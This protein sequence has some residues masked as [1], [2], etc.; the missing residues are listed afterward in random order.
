[1]SRRI[2]DA[3]IDQLL[4]GRSHGPG[5]LREDGLIGKLSERLAEG[6]LAT[7][8][9]VYLAIGITCAGQKEVLGLWLEQTE[10]AKCWLRVMTD[11]KGRGVQELLIAVVDGLKGFLEAITAVF[12]QTIVQ[13][14]IVHLLRC[15]LDLASWKERRALAAALKPI[16]TA[17][18]AEAS[19]R[20]WRGRTRRR[21]LRFSSA[22]GFTSPPDHRSACTH[23]SEHAP[24]NSEHAPAKRLR[25][26][27]RATAIIWRLL[28]VAEKR[29]RK[30]S[31][32]AM[33]GRVPHR[34]L[35][36]RPR[37]AR[38]FNH[39]KGRRLTRMYTFLDETSRRPVRRT[40]DPAR[41][42]AAE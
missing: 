35:R 10:G 36:G 32:L 13:T 22:T 7:E 21:S 2:H 41:D 19:A 26:V 15:S 4:A 8:L 31:P 30:L 3:L 5:L 33:S 37:S 17:L 39:P 18:N 12:P 27:E 34:A 23:D 14:C 1:M 20:R 29:F 24:Q 38:C 6:M 11:L 9:T 25:K 40:D 42:A 16:D 28:Q